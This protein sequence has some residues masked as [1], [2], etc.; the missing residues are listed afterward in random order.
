[1]S[2]LATAIAGNAAL[3]SFRFL[4]TFVAALATSVLLARMLGPGDFGTYRLAGTIIWVLEIVA[5]LAF[6][7]ATTRFTAEAAGV[8]TPGGAGRIV[9]FFLGRAA[10]IYVLALGPFL[11]VVPTVARFYRDESL[12]RLLILG[13]LA[14]LPG[15]AAG[16]LTA[17]L[18][19]QQRFRELGAIALIQSVAGLAGTGFVL[20]LGG[21]LI[22]LFSLLLVLNLLHL[23]LAA[24]WARRD[25]WPTDAVDGT[26]PELRRR[27]NRYALVMGGISVIS[28]V[29]WE[30]SEVFFLGHFG[31][32][33][34]VAFYSL[35]FTL[36]L[37]A[38][39]LLPAAVGEVLF[40][41]IA[42]LE[43][44]RDAWGVANAAV[45]ATRYLA[46]LGFPLA[47][48]G[49]FLAGPLIH[50]LFGP[51]WAPAAPVLALLLISAGVVALSHPAAS[52]ILSK[53]RHGFLF[54]SSIVLAAIN[55]TLDFLLIPPFAAVGAAIANSSVQITAVVVQMAF[56]AR[57]L[58]VGFPLG[59][60]VR[61]L[62][63]ALV[64]F[65]PAFALTRWPILGGRAD[66]LFM[67]V[68]F[69]LMYPVALRAF[70]VFMPE[71]AQRARALQARLPGW[72]QPVTDRLVRV[73]LAPELPRANVRA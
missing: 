53:E 17:G 55:I 67:A 48:G 63:A 18:Q 26:P 70:G 1:M 9:R 57:L 46:M 73:V 64:A 30:R 50:V 69:M 43:G 15:V 7:N 42:R 71:D 39:R 31:T 28:A 16:I 38:R 25:V 12:E 52:V 5:T 60:L 59:N 24:A 21:G 3:S 45:H 35:A 37:Q 11:L 32:P 51:V 13:A 27:M 68:T 62:A 47:V 4:T 33:Q 49:V 10:L 36:S 54:G 66:L 23:A 72:L 2:S 34:D 65:G 14:V 58:G 29:V 19:G 22:A 61:C 8:R 40:P 41:V 20:A 44:L 6:A 56:V